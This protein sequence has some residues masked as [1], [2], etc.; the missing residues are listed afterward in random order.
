M[1][2]APTQKRQ[3]PT[4]FKSNGG[5]RPKAVDP[6]LVKER[7][8]PSPQSSKGPGSPKSVKASALTRRRTGGLEAAESRTPEPGWEGGGGRK[9]D[10]SPTRAKGAEAKV[11]PNRRGRPAKTGGGG[12]KVT[13]PFT[14]PPQGGKGAAASESS[15]DPC[16][17]AAEPPVVRKGWKPPS[18]GG[19]SP[20]GPTAADAPLQT[21]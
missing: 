20:S 16:P 11:L 10:A 14:P 15:I 6:R 2:E 9:S 1:T 4:W 18:Q 13:M 12:L 5:Q 19:G 21:C 3:S 17:Q 8:R 7:R